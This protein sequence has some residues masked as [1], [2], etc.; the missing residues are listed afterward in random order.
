[1]SKRVRVLEDMILILSEEDKMEIILALTAD[2]YQVTS[3]HHREE[4]VEWLQTMNTDIML[5]EVKGRLSLES[6]PQDI[7]TALR[8]CAPHI[9]VIFL[10]DRYDPENVV[11][12]FEAGAK[13]VVHVAEDTSIVLARVRNVLRCTRPSHRM[14]SE[15]E[16]GDMIIH[17]EIRQVWRAGIE[18]ELTPKEFDLLLYLALQVNRVCSRREIL[19]HVWEHDYIS[20]TNVVDVY[21]RHLRKK[22]DRG[23]RQK[24]IRTKRGIGYYIAQP[25]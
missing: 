20:D 8:M 13:D 21:I 2:G 6:L 14:Q 19:R 15:L 10:L 1:M 24:L 5:M 25:E 7:L 22:L 11:A 16:I 18:V 9:P 17:Q 4:A 3:L 12:S 23:H